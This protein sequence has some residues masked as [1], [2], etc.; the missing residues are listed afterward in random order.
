IEGTISYREVLKDLKLAETVNYVRD[1]PLTITIFV[2]VMNKNKWEGLPDS[3]KKVIDELNGEMS[4][5]AGKYL[6][7]HVEEVMEWSQ[8]TEGV[9]VLTLSPEETKRWEDTLQKM[10][11][12]VV[13][14]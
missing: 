4:L 5:F 12:N 2:A 9:E 3:V 6:D 10:Q 7:D 8:D 11:G 14:R 13:D 1:Y